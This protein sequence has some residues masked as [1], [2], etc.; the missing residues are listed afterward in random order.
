[1]K[2]SRV[3][4]STSHIEDTKLIP[5]REYSLN[6]YDI[7]IYS[8]YLPDF[9]HLKID[10]T[11]FLNFLE[12]DRASRFYNEIDKNHFIIYRSILK[13]V[14][15]AY[16][17]MDVKNIHL[18]FYPNKKPYLVSH[19]WLH[20][21][22]SHSKDFTV[23]A[24]SRKKVGIDIEYMSKDF[25]FVDL[26]PV[27]FEKKEISTIQNAINKTY[28]FYTA[29]TRKEAFVKAL[30]KG[31]DEDFKNVPCL[32]GQHC[33]DFNFAQSNEN[34]Q[35]NTFNLTKDYLGALA[36][37]NSSKN[38]NSVIMQAMPNNMKD[39]FALL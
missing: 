6:T 34:W 32:D 38:S 1:M 18:D 39:L 2:T 3:I 23:I 24:I 14:L 28:S 8:I 25:N 31:I 35:V 10:L 17:K 20:F 7:V 36:F 30:G 33:I 21:N 19:P 4:I 12:L 16:T 29:W 11:R 27:I 26:L 15:A 37:E 9:Y 22:I 13:F 5:I